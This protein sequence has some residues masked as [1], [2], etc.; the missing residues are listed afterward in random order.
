[1]RERAYRRKFE[2][3]HSASQESIYFPFYQILFGVFTLGWGPFNVQGKPLWLHA[4]QVL[5]FIKDFQVGVFTPDSLW[6]KRLHEGQEGLATS[7]AQ[8]MNYLILA[9]V[10]VG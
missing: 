5:S 4:D 1:M 9:K 6:K 3:D 2:T 8:A 10:G 7:S